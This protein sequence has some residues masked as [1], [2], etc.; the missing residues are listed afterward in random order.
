M[1][2]QLPPAPIESHVTNPFHQAYK[3]EDCIYDNATPQIKD[4]ISDLSE[5]H[6]EYYTI[7][8]LDHLTDQIRH[9][10]LSYIRDAIDYYNI[11]TKRLYKHKNSNFND[12]SQTEVGT[13]AWRVKQIIEA[14]GVSLKLIAAGHTQLPLNSSQAFAMSK[15]DDE[16]LVEVWETVLDIY[17]VHEIT[18]EKI[19]LVAYP[20]EPTQLL[21]PN[22]VKLSPATY[23]K[24]V[25]GALSCR[26][27]INDYV[28]N[29]IKSFELQKCKYFLLFLLGLNNTLLSDDN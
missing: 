9:N 4:I 12:W 15:L 29:L 11:L 21:K 19:K 14:G 7:D 22:Y 26:Q 23:E 13:T 18:A 27:S 10:Q 20:P 8:H 2:E 24:L 6:N 3:I 28:S 1:K 25:L 16:R 5:A 17:S